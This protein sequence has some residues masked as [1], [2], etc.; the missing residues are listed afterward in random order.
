MIEVIFKSMTETCYVVDNE[1]SRFEIV[2]DKISIIPF[3]DEVVLK[4]PDIKQTIPRPNFEAALVSIGFDFA[5]HVIELV[6]AA[7]RETLTWLATRKTSSGSLQDLQV[8][9]HKLAKVYSDVAVAR[10]FI[11]RRKDESFPS[12][13]L[14]HLMLI[15]CMKDLSDSFDVC[16]K[17]NGGRGYLSENWYAT[18]NEFIRKNR[19]GLSIAREYI[20]ATESNLLML[21][22]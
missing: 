2:D 22:K 14:F 11:H 13:F 17:L 12:Y 10:S 7:R 19:T 8:S 18:T 3:T 6:E 15:S 20:G 9:K 5:S 1:N 16:V 4:T 21:L